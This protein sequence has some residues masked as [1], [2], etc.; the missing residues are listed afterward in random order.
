[1]GSQNLFMDRTSVISDSLRPGKEGVGELERYTA[2]VRS[3]PEDDGLWY[4]GRLSVPLLSLHT[5][6]SDYLS[7]DTS[8]NSCCSQLSYCKWQPAS[9]GGSL[10]PTLIVLGSAQPLSDSCSVS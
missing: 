3:Q 8:A 10:E 6:P 9:Q 2:W 4:L 7:Q 5:K 1:M